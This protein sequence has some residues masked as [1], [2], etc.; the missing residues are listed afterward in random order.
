MWSFFILFVHVCMFVCAFDCFVARVCV[1]V[2]VVYVRVCEF[3][4]FRRLLVPLV[5]MV[6]L[7]GSS[8]AKTKGSIS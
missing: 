5:C 2:C 4:L 1:C 3:C 6:C 8:K 7:V